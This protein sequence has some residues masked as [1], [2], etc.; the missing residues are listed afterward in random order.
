M[1]WSIRGCAA[2]VAAAGFA[3]LPLMAN[4]DEKVQKITF[5]E[6]D[7]QKDMASKIY[8]LK[9][10]RAADLA[11][12]IRSAVI[13]YCGESHVSSVNDPERNRQMLIVST[14]IDM[15]EHVDKLIAALDRPVKA[16]RNTNI[17]GDGSAY[18]VYLPQF[19]ATQNMLDIM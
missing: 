9:H 11:P 4:A 19:R 13:R 8:T 10:T 2:L 1:N 12:F 17:T 3:G 7:A 5:I 18:G 15:L 6:D 14:G 16:A